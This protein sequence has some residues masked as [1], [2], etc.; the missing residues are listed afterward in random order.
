MEFEPNPKHG[1]TARG[2][3]SAEPKNPQEALDTS[4]DISE[5]SARRVGIDYETGEFAVFDQH[6]PNRYHGH[7]RSWS[8]L[9]P[10]MRAALREAGMVTKKGKIRTD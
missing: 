7:V 1:A 9:S 3:A 8:E 10:K 6:L 4:I 2:K 5:N